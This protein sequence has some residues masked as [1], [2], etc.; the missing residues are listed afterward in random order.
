LP[1]GDSLPA[2]SATTPAAAITAAT[3]AETATTATAFTR[4]FRT[5]FVHG[6]RTP[7]KISAVELGDCIGGFLIVRHFDETKAFAPA[8]FAIR[9]NRGRFN[10][11][12][13]RKQL[14]QTIFSNGKRKVSNVKLIAHILPLKVALTEQ[15]SAKENMSSSLGHS[16]A[17]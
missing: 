8:G 3:A 1:S 7:V 13:L 14:L 12:S 2:L 9:D 10:F 11:A 17:A 6:Y 15:R 16:K 4:R 5:R